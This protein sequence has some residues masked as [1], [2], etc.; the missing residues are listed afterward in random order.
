MY[1]AYIH[2][3]NAYIGGALVGLLS[4]REGCLPA[5]KPHNYLVSREGCLPPSLTTVWFPEL[6][7]W[8]DKNNSGK[9]FSDLS[10]STVAPELSPQAVIIN[11]KNRVESY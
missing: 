1:A 10:K 5:T 4:S 2:L 7:W 3:K 8:T 11:F 6:T 9:L